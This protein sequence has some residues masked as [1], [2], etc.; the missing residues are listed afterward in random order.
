LNLL[1]YSPLEVAEISKK[2]IWADNCKQMVKGQWE[3]LTFGGV[4]FKYQ[5]EVGTLEEQVRAGLSSVDV[6]TTSG[7]GTGVA[8][9]LEKISTMKSYLGGEP[10]GLASGISLEN[11]EGYL[12]Y[13]NAYLVGTGIESSFGVLDEIKVK[14]LR[15]AIE[16]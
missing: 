7:P 14:D 10:L 16:G 13:V 2:G 1:G 8:A 3:A 4:A 11:V 6:V 5:E 9:S 12:P 15:Q